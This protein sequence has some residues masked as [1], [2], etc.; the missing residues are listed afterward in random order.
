LR[1]LE[2]FIQQQTGLPTRVAEDPLT[3]VARGAL[4]CVESFEKWRTVLQSSDDDL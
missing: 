3:A 2:H 1:S 4:A